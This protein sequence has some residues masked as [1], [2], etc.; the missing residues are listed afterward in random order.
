ML[1]S[2][3]TRS[4]CF[5]ESPTPALVRMIYLLATRIFGILR[6]ISA[7]KPSWPDRALIAAL[8]GY[9]PGACDATGSPHPAHCSPGT[10]A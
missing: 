2:T 4:L 10:N 6:Q 7:P 1:P 5:P 8:R 3:S 9:C